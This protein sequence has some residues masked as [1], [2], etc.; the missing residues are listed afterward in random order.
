[1]KKSARIVLTFI[2]G[3]FLL[4]VVLLLQPAPADA[5]IYSAGS[6]VTY[7]EVW[8]PHRPS[9]TGGCVFQDDPTK[10]DYLK[11]VHTHSFGTWYV[12]PLGYSYHNKGECRKELKFDLN[13]TDLNNA[14]RVEIYIDLWRNRTSHSMRFRLNGNQVRTPDV[15]DF[16]SRTPYVGEIPKSELVAGTNVMELWKVDAQFHVHDVAIR[17]YYPTS[18]NAP[19][20]NLATIEADNGVFAA[21]A[22][23]NLN[24]DGDQLTLTA[25]NLSAS[26]RYVEFHG[27]YY[28]YDEDND[29]VFHDWHNLGRNNFHP[30]GV[31]KQGENPQFEDHGTINHIGTVQPVDGQA[32]I[33]W[34]I[35]HI[36]AQS[37]VRFKIRLIDNQGRVRDAAGGV[38]GTFNLVRSRPVL[39]FLDPDFKDLALG[40]HGNPPNQG[41]AT[42]NIPIDPGFFQQAYMIGAFWND[43]WFRINNQPGNANANNARVFPSGVDTWELAIREITPSYLQQGDN[44]VEFNYSF[45]AGQ[46]VEK[47]GPMIV[48][49]RTTAVGADNSAPVE[50]PIHPKRNA[51]FVARNTHIALDLYDLGVG[52]NQGSVEFFVNGSQR[53]P[54]IS[55]GYHQMRLFY[56]PPSPFNYGQTVTVRVRASDLNGNSMDRSYTFT[57]APE[58]TDWDFVSDDFNVCA[59]E[60]SAVSWEYID[61][62]GETAMYTDGE[63][64]VLDVPPGKNFDI[65]QNNVTAARLMQAVNDPLEFEMIVKFE[66]ALTKDI[67]SQGILLEDENG[68]LLRLNF[69]YQ[70]P[71]DPNSDARRIR[72]FGAAVAGDGSSATGL[73]NRLAPADKFANGEP[74]YLRLERRLVDNGGVQT[75]RFYVSYKQEGDANW[76]STFVSFEKPMTIKKAGVYAGSNGVGHTA[77]ID[78]VFNGISPIFPEDPIARYLKTTVVGGGVIYSEEDCANPRTVQALPQP[79]WL[80]GGWSGVYS[81]A[82]NPVT[83]PFDHGDELIA[84]FTPIEYSLDVTVR[85][86]DDDGIES[87]STPNQPGI[88]GSVQRS[89]NKTVY[90]YGDRV[91]L[92]AVA[93]PGW[94][95]EG[96]DGDVSGAAN[97]RTI[98][99]SGDTNVEAIFVYKGFIYL[100]LVVKP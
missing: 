80:F 3:L 76:T 6:E 7:K 20:G 54:Q 53:T 10:P 85:S 25:E 38:S 65:W 4:G 75:L 32:T 44:V 35:P 91:T 92:T 45:G 68:D 17:L 93:N 1:M 64:L 60:N 96:W 48:L 22:G 55:G 42:V 2:M 49:K 31:L 72:I 39:T 47:P 67:Q 12:E 28:G 30:G 83:V 90:Y 36:A 41:T 98:T 14:T 21:G 69:Q 77:V 34:N 95:F 26:T 59:L 78:Y 79:G 51:T 56:Q 66:S 9:F 33:T 40:I 23:G 15:G 57:I 86:I 73:H 71:S 13:A 46:L 58:P 43:P 88:G 100:P 99:V 50:A 84:T 5:G 97:P 89:P 62:L 11:W 81:G 8:V 24:I 94:Q 82:D 87:V 74:M 70:T 63:H 37:N 27:Y 52:I 19:T 18:Y 29:G 61:P 16:A